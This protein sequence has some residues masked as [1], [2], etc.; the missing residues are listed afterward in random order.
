MA[1]AKS[2]SNTYL[3]FGMIAAPVKSYL[4]NSDERESFSIVHKACSS[5]LEHRKHCPAC[6]KTIGADEVAKGYEYEKGR[7]VV[8]EQ[9]ELDTLSLGDKKVEI[10][11]IAPAASVSALQFTGKTYYLGAAPKAPDDAYR[12]IF[13]TLADPKIAALAKYTANGRTRLGLLTAS[14][15]ERCFVLRLLYFVDEMRDTATVARPS[16]KPVDSTHLALAKKLAATMTA[17]AFDLASHHDE[18][19]ERVRAL[20]AQKLEGK[21]IAAPAPAA[22]PAAD[23]MALLQ[24]SLD[25]KEQAAAA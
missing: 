18:Y 4:A 7:T 10:V 11:Q 19:N 17:K 13:A 23:L 8:I 12:L 2:S 15:E 3:S 16:E 9:S 24:A 1:T 22:A 25:G 14:A 6:D 5:K 21:E 20:V